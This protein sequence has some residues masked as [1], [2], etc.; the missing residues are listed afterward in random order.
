MKILKI[1]AGVI[2]GAVVLFLG[3][4]AMQPD[5]THVERAR[6]LPVAPGDVYAQIADFN[7]FP[8]WSPWHEM[9]PN[10][11]TTL[12]ANPVGEGATYEWKGNDQVGHGKMTITD[13]VPDQKVVQKLE[14]FEPFEASATVTFTLTPEGQGTKLVWAYDAPAG[15]MEKAMGLFMDMDAMLGADFEKGLAKLEPVSVAAATA[16]V[17]AE[18]AAAAAKAAEEAAALASAST[19]VVAPQ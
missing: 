15:F 3:A 4:A 13:A 7:Q 2:G 14:F 6:T 12:S 10:Q 11:T 5:H 9:D 17:E 19:E 1:V 16:R 18:A 8:K